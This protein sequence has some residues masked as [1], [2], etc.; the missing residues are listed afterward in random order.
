M[1]PDGSSTKHDV[2]PLITIL[3]LSL[4]LSCAAG[5]RE[6]ADHPPRRPSDTAQTADCV[7]EGSVRAVDDSYCINTGCGTL[8]GNLLIAAD[9]SLSCILRVDGD[10][11]LGDSGGWSEGT[12]FSGLRSLETISGDLRIEGL[13]FNAIDGL[14]TLTHIGGHLIADSARVDRT[15]GLS[16]LEA[17]D[18]DL[19]IGP[20]NGATD[21]SRLKLAD[22]TSLQTI[23]GDARFYFAVYPAL[24]GPP[25][26]SHIGGEL[27]WSYSTIDTVSGFDSLETLGGLSVNGDSTLHGES[28]TK[29]PILRG[30]PSLHTV[31]GDFSLQ[32]THATTTLAGFER[33]TRIDGDLRIRDNL[34]LDDIS[35][36]DA[37]ESVG[38]DVTFTDNT[39]L[40]EED[41]E[42]LLDSIGEENIGGA[43]VIEERLDAGR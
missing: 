22:M 13:T 37:L 27:R 36:L 40:S 14:I 28:G 9:A 11:I 33:L 20:S 19:I 43:I 17:I 35:G 39:S 31:T 34:Y 1:S 30:F 12:P 29:L 6:A 38:G 41:V 32:Y 7:Q 16:S 24:R 8:F 23:G 25:N 42:A 3:P 4:A 2:C 26:L 21:N 18:G 5:E 15:A 10:V